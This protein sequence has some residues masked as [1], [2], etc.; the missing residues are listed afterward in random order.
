MSSYWKRKI[1]KLAYIKIKS[2]KEK[3][4]SRFEGLRVL[5]D[6]CSIKWSYDKVEKLLKCVVFI[7]VSNGINRF[8]VFEK[9][10]MSKN[11]KKGKKW[12][13]WYLD[14]QYL[15]EKVDVVGV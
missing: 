10:Q 9:W 6:I 13:F 7:C 2:K 11:G 3:K 4:R 12:S 15:H 1:V 14:D 8:L 5:K